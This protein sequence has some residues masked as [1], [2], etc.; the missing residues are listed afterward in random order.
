MFVKSYLK[1][2]WTI[3]N[4]LLFRLF[5]ACTLL[6]SIKYSTQIGTI[7]RQIYIIK[8]IFFILFFV[9]YILSFS[10]VLFTNPSARAGY[11]TRSVF[12]RSLI[13]L[14]SEFSFS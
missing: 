3:S 10:L 8:E 2:T 6:Y 1:R 5:S 12:K 7:F 4:N 9:K 13:G 11:D 14:N